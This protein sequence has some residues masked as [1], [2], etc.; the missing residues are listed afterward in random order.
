[1]LAAAD[2]G[3]Y[4]VVFVVV[5]IVVVV[6]DVVVPVEGEHGKTYHSSTSELRAE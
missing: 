2:K 1:M 6:A 5:V 3:P 4:L